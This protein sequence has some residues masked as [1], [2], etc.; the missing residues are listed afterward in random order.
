MPRITVNPNAEV[1]SFQPV[2]AG[3]YTM[4]VAEVVDRTPD[5]KNDLK[6]TLEHVA[7]QS[8]LIGVDDRPLTSDPSNVFAYLQLKEEW[9]GKLRAFV[10]A[11]GLHWSD[12]DTE[13]L[14]GLELDVVLAV[15]EYQGVKNNKA[16]RFLVPEVKAP[17]TAPA[18]VEDDI[19]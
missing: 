12:F 8:E 9:Q 4:R 13:D 7:I 10:E 16:A 18:V 1:K 11:C 19:A 15:D 14:Q 2:K 5:G 3:T 17:Q 6:V